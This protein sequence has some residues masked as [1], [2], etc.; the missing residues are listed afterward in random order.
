MVQTTKI[1]PHAGI[2]WAPKNK[3]QCCDIQASIHLA[4]TLPF[5]STMDRRIPPS[6]LTDSNRLIADNMINVFRVD[7]KTVVKLCDQTASLRQKL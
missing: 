2:M 3:R 4:T 7:D 5:C 1:K 6:D